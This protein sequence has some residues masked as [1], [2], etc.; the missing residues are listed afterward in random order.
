MKV[1]HNRKGNRFYARSR[2]V[3]SGVTAELLLEK[4]MGCAIAVE[5]R[6]RGPHAG[7]RLAD[8]AEGA[9][10]GARSD[11]MVGGRKVAGSI[12]VGKDLEDGNMIRDVNE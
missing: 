9:F 6:V 4:V 5:A 7:H 8:G 12:T 10:H 1:M 3:G 2:G 11:S